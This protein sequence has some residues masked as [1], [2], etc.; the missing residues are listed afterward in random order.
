MP[1]KEELHPTRSIHKGRHTTQV[2]ENLQLQ[3]DAIVLKG[4]QEGWTKAR[5]RQELNK[6]I[7]DERSTLKSGDRALNK[8]KRPWAQ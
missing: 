5:Y 2:S 4:Q 8:N 6:M 7:G 1:T 3:M